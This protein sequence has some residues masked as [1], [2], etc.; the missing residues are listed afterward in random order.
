MLSRYTNNLI[1]FLAFTAELLEKLFVL[2][3][4]HVVLLHVRVIWW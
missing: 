1:A 4:E 3:Y 2:N